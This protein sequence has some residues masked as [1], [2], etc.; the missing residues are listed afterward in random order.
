M[1]CTFYSYKGGVGRSMALANVA[2]LLA[3]Q[4]LRVLMIDFD[5]E[6]PG[7]EQFFLINHS[8]ARRHRGLLDLL[9]SYKESMSIGGDPQVLPPFKSLQENFILP[10]YDQLPAGR[11][12]LLPAGQRE[13]EHQL[14]SYALN[15]RTFDWQDFFFNWAGE[16]FFEWLR[17]TLVPAM[18]DVVL[19]DSRTG[20]TEMGG[21]CAYQLADVIVMLCAANQQNLEGTHSVVE[22]FFSERVQELRQRRPLQVLVV[23]ARVEQRDDTLLQPF[24]DKFERRFGCRTPPVLASA[25]MDLWELMIPYEPRYAFDEQVV[26]RRRVHE[27]RGEVAAA[28]QRLAGAL[29]L[30]AG[31]ET[32]LGKRRLA[33]GIAPEEPPPVHFDVTRRHAGYHAVLSYHRDHRRRME[34]LARRLEKKGVRLYLDCWEGPPGEEWR[35]RIEEALFHSG[36]LVL[37]IGPEGLSPW[38]GE[39]M[40]IA[41]TLREEEVPVIPVLL[42]GAE[43]VPGQ[44]PAAALQ[45]RW[46]ELRSKVSEETEHL[47]S[48][49]RSA[50]SAAAESRVEHGPPYVGLQAFGEQHG[51]LF[52]GREKA[53]HLLRE[54]LHTER[55]TAVVGPSGC[56][57]SSLVHAGLFPAIRRGDLPGSAQ[58]R[59]LTLRPGSHPLNGLVRGLCSLEPDLV[60]EEVAGLLETDPE[61]LVKVAGRIL[62]KEDGTGTEGRRLLLF[63]D[64]FE[65]LYTLQQD[66]A[67]QKPFI[68]NLVHA[69]RLSRGPVIIVA[70]IRGDFF[71]R[72]GEHPALTRLL[73]EN[74]F[75]VPP[76]GREEVRRAIE[77]PSKRVGIAFEPGLVDRILAELADEPG[78]LPLLQFLLFQLWERREDGWLTNAAYDRIGGVHGA[79]TW[80][81]ERVFLRLPPEQQAIASRL[82]LRL[83][84]TGDGTGD[85]R[86]RA[87]LDELLPVDADDAE[88]FRATVKRLSNGRLLTVGDEEGR[89]TVELAHEALIRGWP[90]LQRW[91]AEDRDFLSWQQRMQSRLDQDR[92]HQRDEGAYLRGAALEEARRW[93]REREGD[94]S[95]EERRYIRRSVTRKR[96]RDSV[97]TAVVLGMGVLA[98]VASVNWVEAMEQAAQARLN[99]E[100]AKRESIEADIQRGIANIER[101]SAQGYALSLEESKKK[102]EEASRV[103]REQAARATAASAAATRQ[104][105]AAN[106]VLERERKARKE[107][108]TALQREQA[109]KDELVEALA[110][111]EL[112]RRKAD[113]TSLVVDSTRIEAD[114]AATAAS[115]ALA[116][117]GRRRVTIARDGTARLTDPRTRRAIGILGS[118]AD[119]VTSATFSPNGE[120]VVTATAEGTLAL[121]NAST[122][123]K[124]AAL[125]GHSGQV[126]KVAFTPDGRRMASAGD[127]GTA[128]LWDVRK[129]MQE[130][131]LRGDEGPMIDV[132]FVSEHTVVTTSIHGYSLFWDARSGTLRDR[133]NN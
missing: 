91:L 116:P 133:R 94:L 43:S 12:D 72:L 23:P 11:L 52:F 38:Q 68:D 36:F 21:I 48:V 29:S 5:L 54:R 109:I 96:L 90:R 123:V 65:D 51:A 70:A 125:R 41:A 61:G 132:G 84:R 80:R 112:E 104:A 19:V 110:R 64:H 9:L 128:I 49:L 35:A 39:Q 22:N 24:R 93:M 119:R 76:M 77:E 82:L 17:R 3:R 105:A 26:S 28:F 55:F 8:K 130:H 71:S 40:R 69:A 66:P 30:L 53:L 7:L 97:R 59:L 88:N 63:V 56:G 62:G 113:S 13:E 73:Q 127:D 42:P 33:E 27:D 45:F 124:L 131:V 81:A 86:R 87:F 111:A 60:P 101:D 122:G 89:A 46:S 67:R 6:A 16:M 58:W 85:T 57:K 126:R 114:L 74:L 78:V 50:I 2:D 14:A 18:Y 31:P 75:L 106:D 95:R 108:N 15:L 103:A 129:G 34:Q 115:T 25:G 20:V 44:F 100:E 83:I 107:A 102:T 10:V 120:L 1:I 37:G 118:A 121:W 92:G 117:G 4:G 98:L 47:V 99:G 32:L 79:L